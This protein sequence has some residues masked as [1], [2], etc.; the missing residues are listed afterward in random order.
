MIL[1]AQSGSNKIMHHDKTHLMASM[2]PRLSWFRDTYGTESAPT[3]NC[4][5]IFI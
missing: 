2:I 1:K 5:N 4:V 3:R